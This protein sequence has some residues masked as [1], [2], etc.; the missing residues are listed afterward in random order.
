VA[1]LLAPG[2]RL[3]V[4]EGHPMMWAL[5]EIREEGLIVDNPYFERREPLIWIERGTY[6]ETTEAF[7]HNTTH[8]WNHGLGEIVSALLSNGLTLTG[9]IEHQ[10]IPWNGLPGKMT[11]SDDGEYRLSERPWR[12]AC[13][14]T[15]QAVKL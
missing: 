6:V 8:T 11:R 14:Y 15:L 2:G 9:L 13:S 4:R 5:D 12:L 7:E 1:A 10:T 3:F